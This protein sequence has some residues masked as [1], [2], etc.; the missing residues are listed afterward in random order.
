MCEKAY[1]RYRNSINAPV[2]QK[3]YREVA[4]R[5]IWAQQLFGVR[6][7]RVAAALG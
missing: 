4:V 2:S 5:Q 7:N 3:A 6:Q 1:A